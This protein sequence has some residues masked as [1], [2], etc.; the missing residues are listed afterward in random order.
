MIG[1]GVHDVKLNLTKMGAA[2][3]VCVGCVGER[4]TH[5]GGASK[6]YERVSSSGNE[7]VAP[8]PR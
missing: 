1:P 8:L 7:S 4:G 5:S 2:G 6:G 3:P